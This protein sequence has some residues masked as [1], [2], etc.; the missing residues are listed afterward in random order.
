MASCV[1]T[2]PPGWS[3]EYDSVRGE[4]Y[5]WDSNSEK[6]Q[7]THP[8]TGLMYSG[9]KPLQRKRVVETP[10]S[11]L[12]KGRHQVPFATNLDDMMIENWYRSR[13]LIT[14]NKRMR[15]VKS[16]DSSSETMEI[17][18]TDKSATLIQKVFR[19]FLD[20]RYVEDLKAVEAE[21]LR[22]FWSEDGEMVVTDLNE[23]VKTIQ[24]FARGW[25]IRYRMKKK[26]K[27][28]D[29][30]DSGRVAHGSS[31][32]GK[33]NPLGS[34]F[35]SK[36]KNAVLASGFVFQKGGDQRWAV[37]MKAEDYCPFHTKIDVG[38]QYLCLCQCPSTLIARAN[39]FSSGEDV[40]R[41]ADNITRLVFT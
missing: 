19:G 23:A 21:G 9:E 32:G 34:F 16:P 37:G 11:L 22:V 33:V 39:Q 20:R 28:R 10:S 12:F 15:W 5:Y 1:S 41:V 8:E 30:M 17:V 40:T 31:R 13:G 25:Y 24:K 7:W 38:T 27:V 14:G 26:D 6:S 36:K 18:D 2:L 29:A 4:H 35:V 3:V